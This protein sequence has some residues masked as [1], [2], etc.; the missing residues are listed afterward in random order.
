LEQKDHIRAQR[1]ENLKKELGDQELIINTLRN[2]INDDDKADKAILDTLNKGPPRIRVA[3]RE[4]LKMDIKK[5]KNQ[6]LVLRN[7]TKEKQENERKGDTSGLEEEKEMNDQMIDLGNKNK[8]DREKKIFN[9]VKE[10]L[11]QLN[12]QLNLDLNSKNQQI[13]DL[14]EQMEEQKVIFYSILLMVL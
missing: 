4:E 5:L 10:E 9:Q 6:V 2:S 8:D 3:T 13:L 14:F 12:H 7:K 1:I 11:E